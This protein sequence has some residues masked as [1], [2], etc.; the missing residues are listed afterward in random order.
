MNT[1]SK[2]IIKLLKL[3]FLLAF[4]LTIISEIIL[5]IV[6]FT[7]NILN[8]NKGAFGSLK[9][10]INILGVKIK[11]IQ[12]LGKIEFNISILSTIIIAMFLINLFYIVLKL[13][14]NVEKKNH[15]SIENEKLIFKISS[16]TSYIALISIVMDFVIN[17]YNGDFKLSLDFGNKNLQLLIFSGIIYIIGCIYQNA[18]QLQNENN[19]TI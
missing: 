6:F 19:L 13:L 2:T 1:K 16:L 8:S 9:I 12:T 7:N 18:V 3:V 5:S 14:K 15:F 4:I 17:L 10:N 11:D